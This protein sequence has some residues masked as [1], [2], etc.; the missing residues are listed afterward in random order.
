MFML[1]K[2]LTLQFMC[3][4]L[5]DHWTTS[6]WARGRFVNLKFLANPRCGGGAPSFRAIHATF[7]HPDTST[8]FRRLQRL[9]FVQHACSA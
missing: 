1:R 3:Y 6:V 5:G 8:D 7:H 4:S 9:A 2:L